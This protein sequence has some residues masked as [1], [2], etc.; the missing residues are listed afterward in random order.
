MG[1]TP[2]WASRSATPRY[3]T[4][5]PG[6][7]RRGHARTPGYEQD[8]RRAVGTARSAAYR[9]HPDG[10]ARIHRRANRCGPAG[11]RWP[12]AGT[13]APFW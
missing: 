4:A 13:F 9:D 1:H 12:S 7:Q 5:R 8:Q 3:L 2:G 10:L 11:R 6:W